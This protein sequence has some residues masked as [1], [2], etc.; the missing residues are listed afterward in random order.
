MPYPY[1][2]AIRFEDRARELMLSGD[3]KLLV[4]YETLGG[5]PCFLFRRRTII[6]PCYTFSTRGRRETR[7]RSPW[8]EWT[9]DRYRC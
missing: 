4:D 5:K 3:S 2:W 7:S 9:G 8:R 1:D 6:C